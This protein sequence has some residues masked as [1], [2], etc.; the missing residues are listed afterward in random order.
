LAALTLAPGGSTKLASAA[1]ATKVATTSASEPVAADIPHIIAKGVS[2]SVQTAVAAVAPTEAEID[3]QDREDAIRDAMN[4]AREARAEAIAN[5]REAAAD[6][7]QAVREQALERGHIDQVI[8]M[9]AVGVTPE[10]VNELR[11]VSPRLQAL[12]PA[13][14]AGMKAVGVTPEY[15]REMAAAGFR[16][17][18][19][20]DLTAARAVGVTGDYARGLA[21]AGIPPSIDNYI[22]LR[23]VGVP[24][25][26]VVSIRRSG[27]RVTDPDKIVEMWTVGVQPGDLNLIVPAPPKP[28]KPPKIPRGANVQPDSDP[29]DG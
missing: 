18:T 12:N 9:K 28:P 1:P 5:A 22:Q 8:T 10:Y 4:A 3:A 2:T 7:R 13:D 14:F 11:S 21:A 27:H 25:H 19:A 16:N 29:G 20:D 26:Y 6:A 24:V 23:A 15:A 17:I